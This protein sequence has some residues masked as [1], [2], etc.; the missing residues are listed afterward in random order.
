MITKNRLGSSLCAGSTS[1]VS[2]PPATL[3][4]PAALH[5]NSAPAARRVGVRAAWDEVRALGAAGA[6]AGG[7]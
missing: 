6:G 2:G 3:H 1:V 7:V 4:G 5:G